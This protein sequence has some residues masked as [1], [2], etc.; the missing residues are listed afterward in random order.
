MNDSDLHGTISNEKLSEHFK[1]LARNLDLVEPNHPGFIFKSHLDN[2]RFQNNE[3]SSTK[4]NL[5]RTYGNVFVN[6]GNRRSLFIASSE[7]NEDGV[8][9]TKEEGQTVVT[10]IL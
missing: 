6:E 8:F 10:A 2:R 3:N 5:V 9:K 7:N 1:S 4:T